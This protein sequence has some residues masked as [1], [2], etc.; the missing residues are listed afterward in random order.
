M[1]RLL[2]SAGLLCVAMASPAPSIY[3]QRAVPAD[4]P[5]ARGNQNRANAAPVVPLIQ[6]FYINQLRQQA[7]Q[8]EISEDQVNRLL[9]VL[10]QYLEERNEAGGTRRLRAQR[11]LQQAFNRGASDDEL[12]R[13]I[14]QFDR[15]ETDVQ[16]AQ[17]RFLASADPILTLRQRAWLRLWQT[18]VEE[19][20]RRLIQEGAPRGS[21]EPA[22]R[23]P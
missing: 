19:R 23:R 22:P 16:A 2:L 5:G 17:A 6:G 7:R 1:K 18:R 4:R 12:S 15:I 10:R 3:G 20:I 21:D 13:L 11:E 8:A 9:P 14:Q